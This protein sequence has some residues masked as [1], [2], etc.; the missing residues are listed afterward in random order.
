MVYDPQNMDKA[1]KVDYVRVLYYL[2]FGSIGGYLLLLRLVFVVVFCKLVEAVGVFLFI[3]V[4]K[5]ELQ[6]LFRF[7][8]FF[9]LTS[10]L[11]IRKFGFKV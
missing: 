10:V 3:F 6:K 2:L 4:G 11:E 5:V 8:F 9:S 7:L 1:L